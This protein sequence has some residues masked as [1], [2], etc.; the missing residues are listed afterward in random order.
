MQLTERV[1]LIGGG[2]F[3]GFGLSSGAD[4]H[5]YAID[6][7]SEAAII[8]AGLG[9]AD[10]LAQTLAN[11]DDSGVGNGNVSHAF[12]THYH[13]DHVGG[14]AAMREA[15]GLR[16]AMDATVQSIVEA[17]DEQSTSLDAARRVGI[18]PEDYVLAPCPVDDPLEDS[19]TRQIGDLEVQFLRTPG[20]S[21]GHGSFVVS[22]DGQSHLFSGDAVFWA[23]RTLTQSVPDCDV[24]AMCDSI[25]RLEALDF[26]GFFPGHGGLSITGGKIHVEFAA[27]RIRELGVP[28]NLI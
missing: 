25:L 4:C 23:G 6:G 9:A 12:I 11:L 3:T 15:L 19:D 10:G 22:G 17:G 28:P 2:P 7:G 18:F 21:D 8:D 16:V 1:H 13:A 24:V 14:A 20:H 5:I 26:Q 27:N